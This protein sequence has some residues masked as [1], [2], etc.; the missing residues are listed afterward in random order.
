MLCLPSAAEKSFHELLFPA[1]RGG[2]KSFT[3]PGF[4]VGQAKESR[5]F[6]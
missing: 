4:E 6:S 3:D 5:G 1:R 2:Y